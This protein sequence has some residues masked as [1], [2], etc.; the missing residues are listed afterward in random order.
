MTGP[1]SSDTIKV[2]YLDELTSN[3]GIGTVTS[4]TPFG[5]TGETGVLS[6]SAST[7]DINDFITITVVDGNLNS[8]EASRESKASGQWD[9][10]TTNSRGD[11]LSVKA[12]SRTGISGVGK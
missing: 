5:A 3:G 12:Y 7:A 2:S 8:N 1:R 4:A 10:T 6:V 11:R 9:G